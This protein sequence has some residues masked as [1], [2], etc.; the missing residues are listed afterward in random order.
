MEDF[1]IIKPSLILEPFVKQYWFLKTTGNSSE[2]IR[3]VPT[4]HICMIFH[5]GKR[6]FSSSEKH[7]QPQAFV[8]GHEKI[9]NDLLYSGL[10]DMI[11]VVFRPA[12]A[13]FFFHIPLNKI[14]G[15][16]VDIK[17]LGDKKLEELEKKLTDTD[18]AY[19]CVLLIEKYL[20]T[21][22]KYQTDHNLKRINAAIKLINTQYPDAN[23]LAEAACLSPRQF[24]RIFTEHVGAKPKEFQRIIR[25]QRALF[26]LQH[27]PDI[28]LAQ[29]AIA[30]GYYDQPHLIKEFKTFSGYTPVEYL[31]ICDPYS[32]YFS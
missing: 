6:I 5:R 29:L 11:C 1:Q 32:D 10:I 4:G 17:D 26:L 24:N 31:S 7:L 22:L 12:G 23:T 18:S 2:Q 16:S 9:Y 25:F 3:T 13:G 20:L 30:C 14:N 8:S 15:L 27:E 19:T 28:N 21:Q